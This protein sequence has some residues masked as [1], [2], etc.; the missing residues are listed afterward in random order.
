MDCK[1]AG[2]PGAWGV[3]DANN[4]NNPPYTR[5]LDD[6]SK[7]G[8]KGI[9]LGPYGYLP[10]DVKILQGDLSKR[11]LQ[12]VAGTIYD[13]LVSEDNIENAIE[14]THV[15]CRLLSNLP[16]TDQVEGQRYKTPY[17]VVIDAVK[18][19]RSKYAGH[20][21]TAPRLGGGAYKGLVKHIKEVAKIAKSYGIRAVLHPHAGGYIEF[22]DEIRKI[23]EDLTSEEIGLCLDTGHLY[24]SGMDPYKWLIDY[25]DR[26]DYVHF[27][28]INKSVYDEVIKKQIDF[29]KACEQGVMCPIGSG[30]IDYD[31]VKAA[32][33][34]IDY[35]GWITIEQERDP[36]ESDGSL[37]DALKS[38]EYLKK[39]GYKL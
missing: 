3:E 37:D 17:L 10:Q 1:I 27:K 8:Y 39:R 34:K 31:S 26:L 36:R 24:Y 5:V 11:G 14:K 38:I 15:T 9:E 19:A 2:A 18:P 33:E 23:T 32:L 29:F 4:P 13:D 35:R 30:I 7:A 6:A 25:A 16:K 12:I 22:E 21:D 20:K 28:D